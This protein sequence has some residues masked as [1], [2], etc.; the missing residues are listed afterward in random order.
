RTLV[1]APAFQLGA[2]PVQPRFPDRAV[3]GHELRELP[4]RLRPQRV[5]P[6]PTLRPHDDE[7]RVFQD[8]QLPRN[9]GLSDVDDRDQLPHRA[10]P[11]PQRLHDTTPGRVGKDLKNVGH[12]DIL[13]QRYMSCQRYLPRRGP[14]PGDA[15]R[16]AS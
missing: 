5:E 6:A 1:S 9:T 11:A 3:R 16:E 7:V 8:G 10:L 14:S 4:K 2:K 15:A 13:L 12:A